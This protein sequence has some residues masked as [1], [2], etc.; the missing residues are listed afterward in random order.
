MEVMVNDAVVGA[1]DAMDSG[2]LPCTVEEEKELVIHGRDSVG[3]IINAG[4][5]LVLLGEATD[6]S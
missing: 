1:A 6:G 2:F 3:A 5:L 4:A